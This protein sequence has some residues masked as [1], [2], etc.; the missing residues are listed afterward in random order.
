MFDTRKLDGGVTVGEWRRLTRRRLDETQS[1][2]AK[3]MGISR[4]AYIEWELDAD[5]YDGYEWDT[6]TVNE[7]LF[8]YRHRSKLSQ[9]EVGDAIGRSSYWVREMEAGRQDCSTLVDYWEK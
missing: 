4:V 3:H 7:V 6:L 5:K 2:M 8:L 9:K 1:F